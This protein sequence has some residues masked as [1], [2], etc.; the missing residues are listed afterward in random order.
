MPA[1]ELPPLKKN[2]YGTDVHI[3]DLNCIIPLCSPRCII[4]KDVERMKRLSVIPAPILL[5]N[6]K[7]G[8]NRFDTDIHKLKKVRV[9]DLELIRNTKDKESFFCP[10]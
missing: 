6:K 9:F 5:V 4:H 7:D 3:R 8:I 1:L 10:R 2:E